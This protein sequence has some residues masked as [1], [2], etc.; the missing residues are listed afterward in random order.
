MRF[1]A[2]LALPL[3]LSIC[4]TGALLPSA[5]FAQIDASRTVQIS[6]A[7][8][9]LGP[10]LTD[11][12]QQLG[13]P[14]AVDPSLVSHLAAPAISG[15]LT[16]RQALERVLAGTD[17]VA[18]QKDGVLIVQ[19]A[20]QAKR[21]V[22]P[23]AAVNVTGL[24]TGYVAHDSTA[25][26]KTDTPLIET[27]QSIS[28]IT[29]D[30]MD[31]RAV[32]SVSEALRY[33]PGVMAEAN[34]SL[35]TETDYYTVR[36]F[37]DANPYLDGLSTLTYFTVLAPV[38]ETEG[39]ERVEVLRG[40][41]SVLYGQ[42]QSPGGMVNAV[43]KQPTDTPLHE[44]SVATGSYG[45]AEGSFDLGGPVD[46]SGQWLYRV[47]G[48][49]RDTGT[50]VDNARDKRYFLAPSLTWKPSDDTHLTVL[51]HFSYRDANN[52]PNDLPAQGTLL[53]NPNGKIPTDFTDRDSNFDRFARHEYAI[54]YEF[55]HRFNDT[56]T[57]RQNVRY[58]H[59]GL[60]YDIIG[61]A[62]LEDDLR[63]MDRYAFKAIASSDVVTADN[64]VEFRFDTGAVRQTVL[65]GLDYLHSEDRWAEQ[66]ASAPPIDIFAPVYGVTIDLPAVDYSAAHTIQQLGVYAQDQLRWANWVATL[67]GRQDWSSTATTDRLADARTTQDSDKFTY[68]AGL[69]YLFDNGLAPY[70]S[71]S[72]SFTP[73]IGNAFNG[74][75]FNPTLG[76]SY[77]AGLKFQPKGQNSYLM[78]SVY[79]LTQSNVLTQDPDHPEFQVQS[80]KVR[81]RGVELSGVS[82]LGDGLS[83][84]ASYTYMDG[85]QLHNNDGTQGNRPTNV[86]TNMANVWLDKSFQ[87]G[88]LRGFGVAGGVRYV[89]SF[90]GD[91]ENTLRVPAVTL[92]DAAIRYDV[93]R[94]RFSLNAQNLFD[95]VYVSEC[96]NLNYCGYGLRRSFIAKATYAW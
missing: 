54:G 64:Q 63:T 91:L 69:V 49:A 55:E 35:V 42:A 1:P 4:L 16:A 67:S 72:T 47:T 87:Q 10:A 29:R 36:G 17:L 6:V 60:D 19:R 50:Q 7:A 57:V 9:P 85:R 51:T 95:K 65:V 12:A 38:I 27:P 26:T 23:L 11:L 30:Q 62:G 46:D 58:A 68:R 61:N 44:V 81:V 71:T 70:V 25:G 78:A 92:F 43:S 20:P 34:G 28:V 3:A 2:P 37:I 89:A 86:P 56:V 80:G 22:T 39:L 41:A 21:G 53:P 14:L 75:P 45:R 76:K 79:N 82:D 8:G 15:R 5:V 66:D 13:L 24:T 40:P 83:L 31:A 32:Q 18:T 96:A 94:W 84:I 59:A 48:L 52:L 88:V 33:T 73:S 74:S 93:Q 77:E 90:Y